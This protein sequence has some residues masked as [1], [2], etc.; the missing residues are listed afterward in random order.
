MKS[1]LKSL[2]ICSVR[3]LAWDIFLFYTSIVLSYLLTFLIMILGGIKMHISLILIVIVEVL[4][5]VLFEAR[6]K[7][8]INEVYL[9][10]VS[11]I[12]VLFTVDFG[13]NYAISTTGYSDGIAITGLISK[14]LILDKVWSV[15]LFK[16]YY[17][18][19]LIYTLVMIVAYFIYRITVSR[20]SCPNT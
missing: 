7:K 1:N 9:L 18:F 2:I 15:Q 17:Q 10:S 4:I 12:N 20:N 5:A 16:G 8:Q 11:L 3:M 6:K 13:I 19:Q 14:V